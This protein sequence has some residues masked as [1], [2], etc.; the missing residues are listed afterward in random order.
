MDHKEYYEGYKEW[1]IEELWDHLGREPTDSEID[2]ILN[3]DDFKNYMQSL[4]EAYH[5]HLYC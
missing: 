5:E 2:A 3:M 1:A 4:A